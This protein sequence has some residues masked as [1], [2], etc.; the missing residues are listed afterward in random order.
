MAPQSIHEKTMRVSSLKTILVSLA[1]GIAMGVGV[2]AQGTC[3]L[4][5]DDFDDG[6]I[7]PEWFSSSVEVSESGGEL[8]IQRT[9][10]YQY[11]Q[12]DE[13]Q[14]LLCGDVDASVDFRLVSWPAPQNCIF[15]G[16]QILT[17]AG[18]VHVAGIERF[19]EANNPGCHSAGSYYKA[20]TTDSMSCGSTWLSTGD[21]QGRFRVTRIGDV[22]SMYYD[23]GGAWQ[24]LLTETGA[25]LGDLR[26]RMFSSACNNEASDVRFDNLIVTNSSANA[27]PGTGNNLQMSTALGAQPCTSGGLEDIKL[28]TPGDFLTICV[29]SSTGTLNG[30]PFFVAA[31]LSASPASPAMV[32]PSLWIDITQPF[33]V[34]LDGSA[35]GPFGPAA[36]ISPIGTQMGLGIPAFL[37]GQ[38]AIIQ[39][40]ALDATAP[41]GAAF[42]EAHEI[43]IL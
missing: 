28:A 5:Q 32:A 35:P 25:P 43:R 24:L 23:Q 18:D 8:V 40:A 13:T 4:I 29:S 16:L 39:V 1:I 41:V 10:G 14:L 6:V 42:S 11:L 15:M 21:T 37:A 19:G 26:V 22:V 31:Q 27:W 38:S 7:G 12:T 17:I 20:W 33:L 30:V 34:L 36:V 9:M 3:G 2:Q